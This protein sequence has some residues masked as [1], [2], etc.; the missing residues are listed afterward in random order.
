MAALDT[1]VVMIKYHDTVVMLD[2]PSG[3]MLLSYNVIYKGRS[4]VSY[5]TLHPAN[6]TLQYCLLNVANKEQQQN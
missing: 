2:F 6:H 1:A 4:R 5:A 3:L